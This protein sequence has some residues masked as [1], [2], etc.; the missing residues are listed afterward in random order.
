MQLSGPACPLIHGIFYASTPPAHSAPRTLTAAA[1]RSTPGLCSRLHI[2]R[3][4]GSRRHPSYHWPILHRPSRGRETVHSVLLLCSTRTVL[5]IAPLYQPCSRTPSDQHRSPAR[6]PPACLTSS[7]T[8]SRCCP[9]LCPLCITGLA[10]ARLRTEV[11]ARIPSLAL[12]RSRERAACRRV[13][14]PSVAL[15]ESINLTT[16]QPNRM[17]YPSRR[18]TLAPR[19]FSTRLCRLDLP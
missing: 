8:S 7:N 6:P 14:T 16:T 10:I 5:T 2:A 13:H 18:L 11:D 15:R 3:K 19:P 1:T 12:D 4:V 9:H 17:P